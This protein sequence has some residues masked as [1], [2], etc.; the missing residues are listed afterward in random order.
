MWRPHR[1]F[2]GELG[3][4]PVDLQS[5]LPGGAAISAAIRTVS[6][7]DRLRGISNKGISTWCTW[8]VSAGAWRLIRESAPF[9]QDDLGL[10]PRDGTSLQRLQDVGEVPGQDQRLLHQNTGAASRQHECHPHLCSH[11]PQHQ[12]RR[13]LR[14]RR[15]YSVVVFDDG[16]GPCVLGCHLVKR[17]HLAH[18]PPPRRRLTGGRVLNATNQ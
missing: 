10:G 11:I 6:F 13:V 12:V 4:L 14:E 17:H 8:R 15:G 2:L 7:A 16:P 1:Q 3:G 18:Q 5:L 9:V